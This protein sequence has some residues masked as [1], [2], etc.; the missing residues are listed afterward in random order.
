MEADIVCLNWINQGFLSL[1]DIDKLS[2]SGK[3]KIVWTM[4]DMWCRT[5]ICHH[6][7]NCKNYKNTCGNCQFI[8]FKSESDISHKVWNK[9]R[10]LYKSSDINF[11]AVSSWLERRCGESSLLADQKV[12]VIPNALPVSNFHYEK[13]GN[14]KKTRIIMGATR[15]D[16]AVKRVR[17]D[18]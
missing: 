4:H 3:K 13:E 6:A 5:G 12:T 8:R 18:D 16:E 15:L 10:R 11:I 9:K 14:T 17:S 7:Y 2:K 1:N